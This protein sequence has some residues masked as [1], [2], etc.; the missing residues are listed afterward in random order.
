MKGEIGLAALRQ[1]SG[2]CGSAEILQQFSLGGGFLGGGAGKKGSGYGAGRGSGWGWED[3]DGA[4][5]VRI[6]KER[7]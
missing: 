2:V 3:L 6:E 7:V 4:G 5:R 1:L